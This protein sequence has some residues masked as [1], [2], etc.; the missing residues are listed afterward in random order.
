MWIV[1]ARRLRSNALI[2]WREFAAADEALRYAKDHDR[3]KWLV[4]LIYGQECGQ[5]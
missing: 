2:R 3:A 1:K 4:T 5:V